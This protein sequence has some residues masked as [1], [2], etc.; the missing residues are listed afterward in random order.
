[1]VNIMRLGTINKH[2]K[3][4]VLCY[5]HLGT[6][7]SWLP[8]VNKIN[9]NACRL[10]YILIIPDTNIIKSFNV[11][12]AIIKI[13][14]NIFNEVLVHV[15]DD[16]W[17]KHPSIFKSIKWY[18]NNKI[19][20]R[21]FGVLNRSAKKYSLLFIFNWILI[22]LLNKIFKKECKLKYKKLGEIISKNDILFYDIHAE[23]SHM[24]SGHVVS[25]T[26]YLFKDNIKYSL[27]HAIS[28]VYIEKN[29]PELFNVYNK[30]N[31]KI[32]AHAKFQSKYYEAT[33]GI[34]SSKI[35]SIGIPRHNC[36]W[37]KTI[38][39]EN[40]KL[41]NNFNDNAVIILSRHIGHISFDEKVRTLKNIKK[42]FVDRLRMRVIIKLHPNEKKERM[43]FNKEENIYE[44]IFG[45]NNYELT[46]V[47][48][49][50]HIFALGKGNKL[51]ISLFTGVVLDAIAMG[52]PCVEYIDKINNIENGERKTEQFVKY[53]FVER[54][55]N[56][57]ELYT[58]VE[59]WISNPDQISKKSLNTYMQYFRAPSNILDE[60]AIEIL[61][62]N[63][64]TL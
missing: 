9:S 48:S 25:D 47:Y 50:L 56:Y 45:L 16:L 20:L 19:I 13:A 29:S 32:Y 2:P 17:I 38:Q 37:I 49:D 41:P 44:D 53:G 60:V 61:N 42:I 24:F 12:N 7:D 55:S 26:L 3:I 8:I 22:L 34:D 10:D 31:I 46:W 15:D 43:F 28:V 4:F 64:M 33:Y 14:N 51:A 1:V 18:K 23:K 40:S 63:K 59:K 62:E 36:Q 52:I 27:P 11:D 39:K 6:L 21:I 58:F 54:V 5:P 57:Q 35:K 30:N